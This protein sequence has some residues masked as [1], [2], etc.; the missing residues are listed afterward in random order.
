MNDFL[1]DSFGSSDLVDP[2]LEEEEKNKKR[3]DSGLLEPAEPQ[4]VDLDPPAPKKSAFSEPGVDLMDSIQAGMDEARQKNEEAKLDAAMDMGLQE[5]VEDLAKKDQAVKELELPMEVVEDDPEGAARMM[6]IKQSKELLELSP[7]AKAILADLEK[8]RG[9]TNSVEELSLWEV[10]SQDADHGWTQGERILELGRLGFETKHTDDPVKRK[11]YFEEIR[12]VQAAMAAAPKTESIFGGAGII[13]STAEQLAI[14]KE[15]VKEGLPPAALGAAVNILGFSPGG[16][17]AMIA[18]GGVGFGTGFAAGTAKFS[19]EFEE[20]GSYIEM[21]QDGIDPEVASQISTGVGIINGLLEVG[22]FGILAKPIKDAVVK[23]FMKDAQRALTDRTVREAFKKGGKVYL[24]TILAEMG[25]ELGQETSNILGGEI[26]R[27]MSGK[28]AKMLSEEG[29]GELIDQYLEIAD[30]TFKSLL[31]ISAPGGAI[32]TATELR[33]VKNAN[34]AE[35]FM[36]AIGD[37]AQSSEAAEKLPKRLQDAVEEITKDGPMEKVYINANEFQ[38]VFQESTEAVAE[39]LGVADQLEANLGEINGSLEVPIGVY[40]T[41]VARDKEAHAALIEHSKFDPLGHTPAEVKARNEKVLEDADK[42]LETTEKREEMEQSADLVSSFMK[43]KLEQTGRH[44]PEQVEQEATMHRAFAVVMG[45]KIGKMPHEVYEEVGL[46][47]IESVANPLVI[48]RADYEAQGLPSTE[49][50]EAEGYDAVRIEG[51]ETQPE[52]TITVGTIKAAEGRVET[53]PQTL[54]QA[55]QQEL[56]EELEDGARAGLIQSLRKAKNDRDTDPNSSVKGKTDEELEEIYNEG[57]Q[58]INDFLEIA[59]AK[60]ISEEKIGKKLLTIK[61]NNP[62]LRFVGGYV[63]GEGSFRKITKAGKLRTSAEIKTEIQAGKVETQPQTLD[64]AAEAVKA[65][66]GFDTFIEDSKVVDAKGDPLVVYHATQATEDFGV[67][68]TA[69]EFDLGSHFGTIDQAN[70]RLRALAGWTREDPLFKIKSAIGMDDKADI[71]SRIIPVYLSIKNPLRMN[72]AGD[73]SDPSQVLRAIQEAGIPYKDYKAIKE[74]VDEGKDISWVKD[75]IE[76]LGYDGVIYQ[77]QAEGPG[78]S[79]IAFNPKQIKSIFAEKFDL[80]SPDYLEQL[81]E[82]EILDSLPTPEEIFGTEKVEELYQSEPGK[83]KTKKPKPP[84]VSEQT[85]RMDTIY[86]EVNE[87]LKEGV[88]RM[89]RA[90]RTMFKKNMKEHAG[91]IWA[92]AAVRGIVIREIFF[93]SM[94]GRNVDELLNSKLWGKDNLGRYS[95]IKDFLTGDPKQVE[96]RVRGYTFIGDNR[97]AELDI[98]GSFK[99]CNPSKNCA[100]FCYAADANARPT[101]LIKAEFT[102]W[103]AENHRD[104]LADRMFEMFEATPQHEDGLALRINDKGDLSKAQLLLIQEMNRRGIRMQIFSKRPDLLREVSDFNL[105]MLS[106]DETNFDLAMENPDLQLAVVIGKG[107]TEAQIEEINDR[108]AVYL[109]INQGKSSVSRAEV[110]ERFPTVFNEMTQKLCPVDGG[111][112]ETKR[113]TSYVD[114]I[115]KKPGTKGLWTCGACDILGSS[116]CFFG[117]NKSENVRKIISQIRHANGSQEQTRKG[118][119]EFLKRAEKDLKKAKQRGELNEDEYAGL[120]RALYEGKRNIRTDLGPETKGAIDREA[121]GPVEGD[122][123]VRG[124]SQPGPGGLGSQTEELYQEE[125]AEEVNPTWYYSTLLDAVTNLKPSKAQD[126][127]A[128]EWMNIIRKLPGVKQEEIAAT[129]LED[130]LGLDQRKYLLADAENLVK[131]RQDLVNQYRTI[132][133]KLTPTMEQGLKDL[134]EAKAN[135]EKLRKEKGPKFTHDQ[136]RQYL[137]DNGPRLVDVTNGIPQGEA[138]FA[139]YQEKMEEIDEKVQRVF[140]GFFQQEMREMSFDIQY[141][142]AKAKLDKMVQGTDPKTFLFQLSLRVGITREHRIERLRLQIEE[143]KENPDLYDD[144]LYELIDLEYHQVQRELDDAAYYRDPSRLDTWE[145]EGSPGTINQIEEARAK[146]MRMAEEEFLEERN[147]ARE[148]QTKF[149][150]WSHTGGKNYTEWLI[151][152]PVNRMAAKIPQKALEIRKKISRWVIEYVENNPNMGVPKTVEERRRYNL[153]NFGSSIKDAAFLTRKSNSDIFTREDVDYY[154]QN[155]RFFVP[156]ASEFGFV[157]L[158]DSEFRHNSHFPNPNIVVHVRLDEREGV[159]YI[160]EVQSDWADARRE[161]FSTTPAAPFVDDTQAYTALALK[162]M[163]HHALSQGF[164]RIEW[165]TGIQQDQRYE[166]SQFIDGVLW[167]PDTKI[168]QARSKGGSRWTA[169]ATNVEETDLPKY[170]GG[171]VAAKLVKSERRE[172][173]TEILNKLE[174]E[175]KVLF[176]EQEKL[177]V[178]LYSSLKIGDVVFNDLSGETQENLLAIG[179]RINIAADTMQTL[180]REEIAARSR[181]L[182]ES[183]I[184]EAALGEIEMVREWGEPGGP[185]DPDDFPDLVKTVRRADELRTRLDENISEVE[186]LE[187]QISEARYSEDKPDMQENDKLLTGMEVQVATNGMR[188]YYDT[189]L[190]SVAKKVLKKLGVKNP[191]IEAANDPDAKGYEAGKQPGFDLA[192]VRQTLKDREGKTKKI[193]LF[194]KDKKIRRGSFRADWADITKDRRVMTLLEDAN[195]STFL[196]E[197]GHFFFEATRHFASQADAPQ[198]LRDD[199]NALLNFVGVSDLATWNNMSFEERRAGHEQVARAFEAYL[200]EGKAPTPELQGMFQTFRQWLI[201]VYESIKKLNVTLSDDVRGVFDRMLATKEDIEA[202]RQFKESNPLFNTQ[203]EEMDN[204][205]WKAYQATVVQ[206]ENESEEELAARV[207]RNMR[208]ESGARGRIARQ[209]QREERA[210]REGV[211]LEATRTI[212]EQDVYRAKAF[213]R[214]PVEKKKKVKSDPTTVDP[215]NDH[216]FTAIAKLGGLD[217]EEVISK[218]GFDPK[219]KLV[220]GLSAT[221]PVWKKDDPNKPD[222]KRPRSIDDMGIVLSQYGYL[223]LDEHGKYDPRD[224]EERF[225]EHHFGN[226]KKSNKSEEWNIAEDYENFVVDEE[227]LQ[228][229]DPSIVNGKLSIPVMEE[230]YGAEEDAAWRQL[231]KGRYGLMAEENGL[232]PDTVAKKFEFTSGDE[233]IKALL[234][235]PSL[236]EAVE[237]ETDRRMLELYGDMNT[238]EQREQAINKALYNETTTRRIHAELTALSKGIGGNVLAQEARA[239]AEEKISRMTPRSIRPSVYFAQER[240]ENRNAERALA[241]GDRKAA[242]EHKRSAVINYH[243]AKAAVKAL[244]E[245][246]KAVRYFNSFDRKGTQKTVAREQLDQIYALL[247]KYDL[248][249]SVTKKEAERREALREWIAQQEKLG[250]APNIDPR[251]ID[252]VERQ[253]YKDTP[254]EELRGLKDSIRSIEHLGRLKNKLLTAKKERDLDTAVGQAVE[255]II[256][257]SKKKK[258]YVEKETEMPGERKKAFWRGIFASHRKFGDIL[259][260]FAGWKFGGANFEFLMRPIEERTQWLNEKKDEANKRLAEIFNK[261]T[262][263]EAKRNVN[264]K[265]YIEGLGESLTK[266]GML[267]VALNWGNPANQQR[268]MGDPLKGGHGWNHAQI[269]AILDQLDKRDWDFVQEVWDFIDEYWEDIAAKEK[270]VSGV[271]PEK[272]E[273][274]PVNTKFGQYRGGYYPIK[275]NRKQ[276]KEAFSNYIDELAEDMKRGAFSR[277]MTK[278]GFVKERVSEVFDPVRLDLGVITEHVNEVIHDLAYHEVLVDT[279]RFLNHPSFRGAV[280]THYSSEIWEQLGDAIKDM[281]LGDMPAAHEMERALNYLK[282]GST[283]AG[284]AWNLGTVVLQPLGLTQSMALIGPKWVFKGMARFFVGGAGME[285]GLEWIQSVSP[286][287]KNRAINL[288]REVADIQKKIKG[289]KG[290][291]LQ[292]NAFYL[293]Q[294]VQL[295]ADVP[296]WLGM[297]EKVMAEGV[298]GKMVDEETAIILADRAVKDSQ[299]SGDSIDLAKMQRGSPAWK[300]FTQFYSFFSVLYQRMHESVHKTKFSNPISIGRL[301][302]DMFLLVSLPVTLELL[303]RDIL[304]KGGCDNGQDLECVAEKLAVGHGTYFLGAFVG[305]RE[306][307]GFMQGFGYSGPTGSRIFSEATKLLQQIEQQEW[308]RALFRSM[309]QTGGILF[310]YPAAQLQRAIDAYFD[311]EEGKDVRPTAPLFGQARE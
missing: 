90:E 219:D 43:R 249:K 9:L 94:E 276:S 237:A 303:V 211:K 306:I 132:T 75:K 203:P 139:W 250:F 290:N 59:K 197:T 187:D 260:Q 162:R 311:A 39:E 80:R 136:I 277:A 205:T 65:E 18:G 72:D 255:E 163:I 236:R 300:L 33:D 57:I 2:F 266:N 181:V 121:N 213:L 263:R 293:M 126:K 146:A 25:I 243:F 227:G 4:P 195:L 133:T 15:F 288:S 234:A 116:G 278:H 101:E 30:K 67:F 99:N 166:M 218:W 51:T 7:K 215:Y 17:A 105:K 291:A 226:E 170:I 281:A 47:D 91:T 304:L 97:K 230:L 275:Y 21:L 201:Q 58:K 232:H 31:L 248:R 26:G 150:N 49:S 144:V 68:N 22:A 27:E 228:P 23:T 272:V 86:P 79:Y 270:R 109:P 246:D 310:H 81:S 114:I 82:D 77:N 225:R 110:K 191:K 298:D 41:K 102:E 73:F 131:T 128:E 194:Q 274:M 10:M 212:S 37:S 32:T 202:N 241:K 1:Y 38:E 171:E 192:Q 168:L 56:K 245:V 142:R 261:Y 104:V 190:P 120:I 88:A 60:N 119:D 268:I 247:E 74:V 164:E 224:F 220:S 186:M 147:Q 13:G 124:G 297:Y 34:Q 54:D 200:F 254:M 19:S 216:L 169:V 242:L 160:Q 125:V 52:Q 305:L 183:M 292:E 296:T 157:E 156:K 309:N 251:L 154:L 12:N 141:D 265:V 174:E 269:Q 161:K 282:N 209:M 210:R 155:N 11:Q 8:G 229:L 143:L 118:V 206:A 182:F 76:E 16:P 295:V 287:M 108:V 87:A 29:R 66:P 180:T 112:L 198:E 53:Q 257:N 258:R 83:K 103:A 129:G 172:M 28:Q 100:K 70:D 262:G 106:I 207:L 69:A 214:Q 45:D 92:A 208:W 3:E 222:E 165:T 253:P 196:H 217:K 14:M 44:T 159:L 84:S 123:E 158:A 252:Q 173:T 55:R 64:Q 307:S 259:R 204:A 178:E 71:G 42:I 50:L 140:K 240:R 113:G 127:T 122:A 152:L 289:K 78:D 301:A 273:A 221:R 151:V 135:L 184:S 302:V 235:A 115:A 176:L 188:Q 138:Q 238:P 24:S 96:K 264:T 153:L 223:K 177:G 256:K 239:W 46:T 279:G 244:E 134:D 231:P 267:A 283:F 98:S 5:R 271:A 93:R 61:N 40:A 286:F 233:M 6:K 95:I 48:A 130:Y 63:T 35:L 137:N 189:I 294:K 167:N 111:K 20:G 285:S 199:M 308:D 89:D 299:G 193:A 149:K 284:L 85:G 145:K 62:V 179:A 148:G 280:E 175:R 185:I 117:K 36:K 107:M